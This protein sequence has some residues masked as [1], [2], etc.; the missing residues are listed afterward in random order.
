MFYMLHVCVGWNCLIARHS[1]YGVIWIEFEE[2]VIY[3][4]IAKT[5]L[6]FFISIDR[7]NYLHG[8]WVCAQILPSFLLDEF[9]SN[10]MKQRSMIDFNWNY[11]T[12]DVNHCS[13]FIWNWCRTLRPKQ[14]DVLNQCLLHFL[15][16]TIRI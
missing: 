8:N 13:I 9:S 7:Q 11:N 4:L 12:F 16:A 15:V 1:N 10:P 6:D 14:R 5:R 3:W 2:N